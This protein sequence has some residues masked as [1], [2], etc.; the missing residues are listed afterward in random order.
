MNEISFINKDEARDRIND[1]KGFRFD[2]KSHTYTLDGVRL[3]SVS[4]WISSFTK[5]FESYPISRN[6]A[7]ANAKQGSGIQN[8][9][10]LRR[11]WEL[12]A[13]H[14]REL[15]SSFHDFCYMYWLDPFATKPKSN[16]DEIGVRLMESLMETYEILEMEQPRGSKQYMMGYT[17]DIVMR[18]RKDGR[19]LVGDFKTNAL[20]T[21]EQY[22]DEKNRLPSKLLSPFD[23]LRDVCIDKAS[24]QLLAYKTL[25]NSQNNRTFTI[26]SCVVIHIHPDRKY[27]GDKG[28]AA[29]PVHDI[30]PLIID[31]LEKEKD[32]KLTV[33]GMI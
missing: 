4:A 21:S 22:K 13:R 14:A 28:Y 10:T 26:D 30:E 2:E 24:I 7:R 8:D 19:I 18:N 25:F 3:K 9:V 29:Y 1:T 31:L 33:L 11:Y 32:Y 27:Y 5:P 12:K 16:Y 17:M 6:A 20:A 15:G 23:E